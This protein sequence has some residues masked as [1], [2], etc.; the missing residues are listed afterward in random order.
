MHQVQ[1]VLALL[2]EDLVPRVDRQ[3]HLTVAAHLHGVILIVGGDQQPH[4][5]VRVQ[6]DGTAAQ[7]VREHG[8]QRDG[9]ELGGEDGA[10][11]RQGVGGGAGGGGDYDAVRALAVHEAAIDIDLELDHVGYLARVQHRLVHRQVARLALAVAIDGGLQQE[12][13]LALEVA[14]EHLLQGQQVVLGREIGQEAEVAPVHPYHR[15]IEPG[16]HPGGPQHVAV[17]ADDDGEIRLLAELHQIHHVVTQDPQ[18]LGD[19][20]LQQHPKTAGTQ[21]LI[22]AAEGLVGPFMVGLADEGNGFERRIHRLSGLGKSC[23]EYT[24]L[25]RG[26]VC[27][28]APWRNRPRKVASWPAGGRHCARY[29]LFPLKAG[30]A[31]P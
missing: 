20:A 30:A 11:R 10:P 13:V 31:S 15:H 24:V 4:L 12:A 23:G 8:H 1:L 27:L 3:G 7:G 2:D 18:G 26:F 29:A 19:P 22:Q 25:C 9:V 6:H 14:G 5:A 16:Q 21:V 17:A 28:H